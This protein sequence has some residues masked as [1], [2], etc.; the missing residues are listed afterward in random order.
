MPGCSAVFTGLAIFA[1]LVYGLLVPGCNSL[2]PVQVAADTTAAVSEIH[3][4]SHGWHAGVVIRRS[5]IPEGSWPEKRDFRNAEYLEVGWGDR[6]Y[7]QARDPGLGA[8]LMAALWPTAS[9]LHVAGF[10]GPVTG[11]FPHSAVIVLPVTRE[12]LARLIAY[13]DAAHDRPD[14]TPLRPLGPGLYG[15]SHY[16][17]ARG[18]FHLFNNCNR[19]TARALRAAGYDIDDSL[20]VGGLFTQLEG[21]AASPGRMPN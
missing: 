18:R 16:Y 15:D 21:H 12:G 19:W 6:D 9:V 14:R 10:P 20:T 17:P 8:M 5:D 4:V 3:V 11:Y 7:Y 2:A 1:L 13:I